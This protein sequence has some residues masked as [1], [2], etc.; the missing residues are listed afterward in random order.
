MAVLA[1]PDKLA[2]HLAADPVRVAACLRLPL[3]GLIALLGYVQ[4][5]EHWLPVVYAAVLVLYAVAATGWL[6]LVMT[7]PVPGWA[8]W[9]STGIDVAA[10]LAVCVVSGGATAWLLPVFFLV[11]ISVAFLDRPVLTAG[12]GVGSAVGFLLAWVVY[13]ARDDT[14][15]M[16]DVVYVQFGCLLWL[17]AATTALCVVLV[18]RSARVRGLLEVRRRLVAEA[19]LAEERHSRTLAEQL[20]DGP[21]QNL[22]AVRLDLDDLREACNGA[23]AD[24]TLGRIE[25]ALRETVAQLRSTVS[26]LHPQVLAQVGL[27][28]ALGELARQHEQRTGVRVDGDIDEVGKPPSQALLYRAARELL[29]N[30]HKHSRADRLSLGLH[31]NGAKLMLV[32]ADDGVGFDPG[33]L[34]QSVADGHIG[35]ASLIVAVEAAGGTIAL[36]TTPGGGTTATITVQQAPVLPERPGH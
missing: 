27:T 26:T 15:D 17:A 28:A 29:A 20:H 31:R 9:A 2:R 16:P 35:L 23:G 22:L 19:M 30:A 34:A 36:D 6:V 25:S 11:P 8:G 24:A 12:L 1:D 5:V 33:V 4:G 7:R 10:V 18:R 32:V 14:V 3:I 21:L 13:A